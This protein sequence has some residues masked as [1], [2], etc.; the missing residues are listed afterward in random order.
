ML[1]I[2]VH[3]QQLSKL[4]LSI[5]S[6]KE[7]G[8][9]LG[10]KGGTA[11]YFFEDLPRFSTDL[12]F[13]LLGEPSFDI[14]QKIRELVADNINIL[15]EKTKRFTWFWLGSYGKGETKIKVEV[16]TRKYPNTYEVRSFRGYSMKVMVKEDMVAHKL[17]AILDRRKM[18]N[19]DLYDAWFMLSKGWGV[20]ENIV[21]LRTNTTLKKYWNELLEML[22]SLP[23]KYDILSGL[24]EVMSDSQKDWVKAKLRQSLEIEIASR[25]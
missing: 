15:D 20:N 14:E 23:E 8:A 5:I 25:I 2:D 3:K 16:N 22:R 13:D 1:N 19:R 18:Q 11:L 6:D 10:F 7:L 4:L 17:C 9:V 24:G 12:D 21:E